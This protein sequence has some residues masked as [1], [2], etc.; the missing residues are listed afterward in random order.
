[1]S[2]QPIQVKIIYLSLDDIVTASTG[3]EGEDDIF[4]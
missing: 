3:D 2:Y 1:M 4:E